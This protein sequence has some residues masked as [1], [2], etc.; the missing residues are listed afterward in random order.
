MSPV[1]VVKSA[2]QPQGECLCSEEPK[3]ENKME[4]T[5]ST[6]YVVVYLIVC[7]LNNSKFKDGAY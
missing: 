7:R 4:G 3:S 5:I 1:N 6:P 2:C